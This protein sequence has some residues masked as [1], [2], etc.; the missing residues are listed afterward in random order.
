MENSFDAEQVNGFQTGR[1]WEK[2]EGLC[3]L[4]SGGRLGATTGGLSSFQPH[5]IFNFP[6][7]PAPY[8]ENGMEII[9]IP[10]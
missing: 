1:G 6:K 2:M 5:G 7:N 3:T 10:R 4:A 9:S 8:K